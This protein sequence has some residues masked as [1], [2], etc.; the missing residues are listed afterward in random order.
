MNKQ[1]SYTWAAVLFVF[2]MAAVPSVLPSML[3]ANSPTKA[4][5]TE[6]LPGCSGAFAPI[7]CPVPIAFSGGEASYPCGAPVRMPYTICCYHNNNP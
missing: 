7:T 3:K 4:T 2:V 1:K 5:L 6:P